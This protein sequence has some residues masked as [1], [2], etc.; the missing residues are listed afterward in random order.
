MRKA[1][2]PPLPLSDSA[3]VAA[4][5]A[6]ILVISSA[7]GCGT[8]CPEIVKHRE[9]FSRSLSEP[10]RTVRGPDLMLSVPWSEVDRL[11]EAHALN[12]ARAVELAPEALGSALSL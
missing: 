8:S 5:M 9:A 1:H 2:R 6:A 7:A 11:L 4:L 12:A 10:D 3:A